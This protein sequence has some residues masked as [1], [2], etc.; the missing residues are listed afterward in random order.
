M[1]R[2]DSLKFTGNNMVFRDYKKILAAIGIMMMVFSVIF[3]FTPQKAQAVVP[4]MD[5][6][7]ETAT[8]A[9]AGAT[10][11][12]VNK[13]FVLDTIAYAIAKQV[14]H[15]LSQS[16][17]DWIRGGFEGNPL[18]ITNFEDFM[19]DQA[20]QATGVF[21]KEFLSPEIY[22]AICS[23]WRI[24]L[25]IALRRTYTY[26]ERM[27]CTLNTVIKNA[28]DFSRQVHEGDWDTWITVTSNPQNNPFGAL[29]LSSDQLAAVIAAATGN[30]RTESIFNAGFLGM[31]ECV[32]YVDNIWTG[33][34][35][36]V[37]YETVSPG[38]WVS[39]QL[40]TATGIDFQTLALADELDEIISALIEQ[41]LT[42]I[43]RR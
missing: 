36:C 9:T 17:V 10:A 43:L 33:E 42:G 22:N 29:I 13:D 19:R 32:Q 2:E 21:M 18:F 26:G 12:L 27:A 34:A 8:A 37:K 31:K 38:K 41:L 15:A 30:A 20:D 25:E 6:P 3:L 16:I 4:V 28:E 11:S 35:T 23:P 5:I 7:T 40:S 24:Q 1:N 39:D 14:L